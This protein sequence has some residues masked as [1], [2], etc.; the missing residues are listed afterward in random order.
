MCDLGYTWRHLRARGASSRALEALRALLHA[1]LTHLLAG[2]AVLLDALPARLAA[3]AEEAGRAAEAGAAEA[4]SGEG[5]GR[6]VCTLRGWVARST[7]YQLRC[8]VLNWLWVL[9]TCFLLA[10]CKQNSRNRTY[11]TYTHMIEFEQLCLIFF[12]PLFSLFC[13][14]IV[15]VEPSINSIFYYALEACPLQREWP[16]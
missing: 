2:L 9:R 6:P 13:W 7:V 12:L 1:C 5:G 10:F 16:S 14:V 8:C 3:W 11:K 15:L 4:V